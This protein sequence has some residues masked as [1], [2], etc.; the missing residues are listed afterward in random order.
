V[1]RRDFVI[2]SSTASLAMLVPKASGASSSN[3]P[4]EWRHEPQTKVKISS[5]NVHVRHPRQIASGQPGTLYDGSIIEF[6][7]DGVLTFPSGFQ[8]PGSRGQRFKLA[9]LRDSQTG[10][11]L[12]KRLLKELTKEEAIAVV[13]ARQS[14]KVDE[15]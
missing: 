1:R 14:R 6:R 5:G 9:C 8:F 11:V 3:P 13:V 10:A 2:L 4:G 7:T 12:K 15:L